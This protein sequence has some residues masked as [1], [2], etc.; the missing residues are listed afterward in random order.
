[1]PMKIKITIEQAVPL[2]QKLAPKIRE[3][4]ALGMT[5]NEIAT[6]LKI[7]RKTIRKV[8]SIL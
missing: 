7:S 8:Y 4:K 5:A 1:M 3:L 6:T 2:Y